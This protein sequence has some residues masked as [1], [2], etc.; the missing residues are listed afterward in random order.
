MKTS[1][2]LHFTF[3]PLIC[4]LLNRLCWLKPSH[5]TVQGRIV[6]SVNLYQSRWCCIVSKPTF[7]T[8]TNRERPHNVRQVHNSGT[9]SFSL[10]F[11]KNW[12]IYGWLES[13]L[14]SSK[15]LNF[16]LGFLFCSLTIT[17]CCFFGIFVS[18]SLVF[19]LVFKVLF[20]C[21]LFSSSSFFSL[22]WTGSF[23]LRLLFFFFFCFSPSLLCLFE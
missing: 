4:G 6:F 12:S 1:T 16:S 17:W 13:I 5:T 3:H 8:E 14:Y 23:S 19:F 21:V 18:L 2:T 22:K 7:Q 15:T 11:L 10:F 9:F 20:V